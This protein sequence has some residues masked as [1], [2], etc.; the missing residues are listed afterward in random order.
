MLIKL[1]KDERVLF[2][3][4][5][6]KKYTDMLTD[7]PSVITSQ[8]DIDSILRTTEDFDTIS[9]ESMDDSLDRLKLSH[10]LYMME[11]MVMQTH[12][13]ISIHREH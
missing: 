4:R 9:Q 10:I 7:Y 2:E 12:H 13:D 5:I 1:L 8:E 6:G 11:S 3:A